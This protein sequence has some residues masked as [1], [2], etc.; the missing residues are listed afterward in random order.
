MTYRRYMLGCIMPLQHLFERLAKSL[1][2]K[3]SYSADMTRNEIPTG[4]VFHEMG[5]HRS[6]RDMESSDRF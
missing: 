3:V 6:T 1:S 5:G 4:R 2:C